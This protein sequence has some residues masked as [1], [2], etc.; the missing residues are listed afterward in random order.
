MLPTQLAG[1]LTRREVL[2]RY[3]S[4]SGQPVPDFRFYRVF[5]LFR[6][7]VIVQQIYYRYFHGQTRD[8]RF[9]RLGAMA[10]ALI[11]QA[12]AEIAG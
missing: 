7:A 11:G 1:S 10:Q 5:G 3:A 9:G 12:T 2:D 8:E 6:L 4:R